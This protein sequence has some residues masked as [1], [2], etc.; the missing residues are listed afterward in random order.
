M[1]YLKRNSIKLIILSVALAV[2]LFIT[3][4]WS[5]SYIEKKFPI[6]YQESV[7]KYA[8]KYLNKS[9]CFKIMIAN[10]SGLEV[11][12]TIFLPEVLSVS[13]ISTTPEYTSFS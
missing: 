4:I 6:K 10:S 1:S 5:N 9:K 7:E 13:S 11:A 2:I 12:R 3:F 8:Q